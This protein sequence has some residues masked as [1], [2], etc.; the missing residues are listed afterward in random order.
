[1]YVLILLVGLNAGE[2]AKDYKDR[3]VDKLNEYRRIP[4]ASNM[5]KLVRL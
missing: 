5:K 1:M 3:I 4:E 2:S